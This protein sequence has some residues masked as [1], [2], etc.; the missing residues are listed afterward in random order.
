MARRKTLPRSCFDIL[1]R[2]CFAHV[3]TLRPDGRLSNHPVGILWDGQHVRFSTTRSRRKYHNLRADPR[4]ALS[5]PDPLNIWRY[6]EIRGTASLEDDPE[7]RF[8]DG[9]ARKYMNQDR[10]PFDPP[11]EQ[12]VTVTVHPEQVSYVHVQV[13]SH[14]GQV[15]QEWVEG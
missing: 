15:P 5:I 8:I 3:A 2:K 9:I 1:E 7:R 14:Q 6:I 12:R 4:I 13:G 10:Y 11:G